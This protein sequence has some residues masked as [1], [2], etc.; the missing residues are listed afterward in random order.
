MYQRLLLGGVTC[1]K[2]IH[3]VCSY[4]HGIR[5]IFSHE[6]TEIGTIIKKLQPFMNHLA[7][8]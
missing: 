8:N 7:P 4:Y 2:G 3:A 5:K 6:L 1:F